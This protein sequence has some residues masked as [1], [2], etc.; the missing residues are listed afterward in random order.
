MRDLI[1]D[2]S[3]IIFSGHLLVIIRL[4]IFDTESP[5]EKLARQSEIIFKIDNVISVIFAHHL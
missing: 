4:T 2:M 1:S 3:I 5:K